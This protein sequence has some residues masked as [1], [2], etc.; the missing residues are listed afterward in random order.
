MNRRIPAALAVGAIA[1]TLTACSSGSTDDPSAGGDQTGD[2]VAQDVTITYT[3]FISNGGNEDNLATIV[4]AFEAA[5][6]GVTVDVTTLPYADYGT[7]LQTDLAAGTVADVFDLEYASYGAYQASGVLA[8]LDGF[9]ASVY[10]PSLLEAYQTDGTQY[11][12]PSSF[13]DVVLFYNKDL[14]DAAGLDYPT[15]SWT[16]ADEQAAAEKLTDA[17]AG[18]WGDYQPISYYEFYK[19]LVQNGAQFLSDDGTSVAFDSPAGIEAAEW[20]IGKSGATMPTAE[21][22]AGTPDFDTT[23]F[24]GGKL[25]MWHTGIWMFGA[26]ADADLNWDIAVE[27]GSTTQASAMFSNALGVSATSDHVTEA[28]AFAAFL[29]GSQD[30]AQVRLDAGW[31]LPPIS[32][33]SVLSS[34]LEK[35]DP[36]NR[37]AVFDSLEHVALPPTVGDKQNEMVDIINAQLTEAAAGRMMAAEALDEAAS[38]INALLAGCRRAGLPPR[39]PPPGSRTPPSPGPAPRPHSRGDPEMTRPRPARAATR[40]EQAARSHAVIAAHQHRSGA[41]PAS[42]TFSAYR[43]Y[44]WLRD[45]SFVADGM[46]RWGDVGSAEAFHDWA[47]GV[48]VDRSDRVGSIVADVAAGRE[49]PVSA[50]LPTRFTLD[51]ADGSDPWWDFQ[52]DGYGMWLWAVTEHARRHGVHLARW[53][54]AIDLATDYLLAVGDRPCYDWW[55]EHVEQVH[56]STLGAVRAGLLAAVAGGTLDPARAERAATAAAGLRSRVL[57][58]GLARGRAADPADVHLAKWFGSDQVD[59]S[60]AACVV[61]FGLAPLGSDLAR[62]TLD[63]VSRDLDVDGGVHRFAADVFYGG[64]Q[65]PLL[66]CLLGWNLLAA[67]DRAGAE[68]HLDWALATATPTGDLPEQVPDHLLHPEHR[69]EWLH[70]WGPV[71]TPLL[72]SHG[73]VLTLTTALSEDEPR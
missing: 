47:A 34:Y 40:A 24:T 71:A 54:P 8:P 5:N 13:S 45:G 1:L 36:A 31:E 19:A 51:G 41:Y 23:L 42:P 52:T 63:A 9:D 37:Q 7:A 53:A 25:A 49:V 29:S 14:F 48:L 38:Q 3:N 20:L 70:R 43:G 73:M 21:Q 64:G 57:T 56:T 69:D 6:P 2:A 30:A 18:V 4:S 67:G 12:L 66:S 50:M 16:W 39:P 60:L 28:T 61:P 35:G 11:A 27:P 10:T 26:A 62:A 17:G 58:D 46:S 65:W 59:A 72:W 68:R 32:D 22:G 55:E 33:E 15:S 44:A